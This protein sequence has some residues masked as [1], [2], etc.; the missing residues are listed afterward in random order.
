MFHSLKKIFKIGEA[1]NYKQLLKS[2]AQIIDVRT[3]REYLS[4]HIQG[5]INIP[6]N[7]LQEGVKNLNKKSVIIICC[8]SGMRSAS[9]QSCL[10][11]SGF[12]KVYNGGGWMTLENKFK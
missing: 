5:S 1:T 3:K 6:L 9:A 2:G 12:T 11:S 7:E 8:A 10:S 4:G